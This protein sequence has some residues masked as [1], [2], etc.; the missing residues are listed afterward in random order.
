MREI[1]WLSAHCMD[2]QCFHGTGL[3][4][5]GGGVSVLIGGP[6]ITSIGGGGALSRGDGV[7]REKS[8]NTGSNHAGGGGLGQT[9][10]EGWDYSSTACFVDLCRRTTTFPCIFGTRMI[11]HLCKPMFLWSKIDNW[12]TLRMTSY[13]Y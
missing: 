1:R 8:F 3:I 9:S 5:R 10:R 12:Y 13:N 7:C 6:I 11:L 4:I 2:E